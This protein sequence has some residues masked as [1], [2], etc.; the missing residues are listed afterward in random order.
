MSFIVDIKQFRV[1]IATHC[2]ALTLCMNVC[3]IVGHERA[4]N[5]LFQ[6]IVSI[7]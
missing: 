3:Y 5:L 6:C 4:R 2:R 1:T 7:L